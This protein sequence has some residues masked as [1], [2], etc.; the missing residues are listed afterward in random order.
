M[1]LIHGFDDWDLGKEKV[2]KRRNRLEKTALV[3]E[4]I[5]NEGPTSDRRLKRRIKGDFTFSYRR[6]FRTS[7][8]I[9]ASSNT[10]LFFLLPHLDLDTNW[11]R[12]GTLLRSHR[13]PIVSPHHGTVT[14]LA[15]DSEWVVVGFADAKIKIFSARTG[16]LTRTLIGH[17]SGVWGLCLVSSGGNR[18]V[19]TNKPKAKKRRKTRT[20]TSRDGKVEAFDDAS[21]KKQKKRHKSSTQGVDTS[22]SQPS[23]R[24]LQDGVAGIDL[25]SNLDG[26][27]G[28]H[29]MPT[30]SLESLVSP[31]MRIALGLEVSSTDS[32]D[33][34][35]REEL[36][37]T[38]QQ[39]HTRKGGTTTEE[40]EDLLDTGVDQGQYPNM[41]SN[42]CFTSQGWGQPNSLIVSGGCDKVVRV[43][44]VQTG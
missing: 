27:D 26:S 28:M 11:R 31:A 21:S 33:D 10:F 13:L 19:D 29:V 36:D 41:P 22:S 4:D 35:H 23:M 14:S 20:R 40:E 37:S 2:S 18:L 1:C 43:W 3:E 25:H 12:G 16:V 34:S 30:E 9:R 15:L 39:N 38:E 42:M 17:E 44:D 7:Y 8:I 24:T 6:H 32:G 5:D